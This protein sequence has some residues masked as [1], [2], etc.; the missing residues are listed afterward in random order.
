VKVEENRPGVFTVVAT[1][2]EISALLAGARMSLSLME[3]DPSGA[4]EEARAA[5]E[6]VLSDF[7]RALSRARGGEPGGE[8]DDP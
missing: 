5:L 3:T 1:A 7:D 6:T 2:H 8:R 4:T